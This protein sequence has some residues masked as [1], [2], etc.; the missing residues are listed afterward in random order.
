[1]TLELGGKSP[2]IVDPDFPLKTAAKRLMWLKMLNAG[3]ICTNVD[4]LFLPE[5]KEQEFATHAARLV[6]ERYP[7]LNGQDTP[8]RRPASADR[9]AATLED[10]ARKGDGQLRPASG[11][12]RRM[13]SRGTCC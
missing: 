8:D 11:P 1:V 3:Q 6:G 4:Y 9:A 2:A 13:C 12:T 10:A 7:D 5:G